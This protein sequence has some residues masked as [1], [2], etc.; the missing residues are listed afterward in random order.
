MSAAWAVGSV[1]LPDVLELFTVPSVVMGT[2]LMPRCV[3]VLAAGDIQRPSRVCEHV[4]CEPF[5]F[6][7]HSFNACVF[8]TDIHVSDIHTHGLASAACV[9]LCLLPS[10]LP[11]VCSALAVPT[12]CALLDLS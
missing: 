7:V 10:F 11:P 2:V 3:V 6:F 5:S 12:C 4:T 1:R 9:L 8:T